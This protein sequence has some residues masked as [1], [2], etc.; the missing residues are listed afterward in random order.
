LVPVLAAPLLAPEPPSDAS[1][2]VPELPHP[3][4]ARDDASPTAAARDRL[5]WIVRRS[6]L[7]GV[8]LFTGSFAQ[9]PESEKRRR[10]EQKDQKVRKGLDGINT[11]PPS[12]ILF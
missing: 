8:M 2:A 4:R 3:V 7:R 9:F 10:I 6:S 12:L 11:S 5:L 1:V